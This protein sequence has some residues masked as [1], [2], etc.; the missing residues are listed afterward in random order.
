M[1]LTNDEKISIINQHLKNI[2]VNKYNIHVAL[3]EES[4]AEAPDGGIIS[5][6]N[7]KAAAE[8]AKYD[9]LIAEYESLS[10]QA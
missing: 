2:V 9:A 1:E 8:Q 7:A 4:A 3:I 6:L 10:G 5:G